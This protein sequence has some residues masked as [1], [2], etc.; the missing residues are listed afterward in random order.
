MKN[1]MFVLALVVLGALAIFPALA[2]GAANDPVDIV[3]A[4]IATVNTGDFD[5]ALAF[6]SDDA[7][8]KNPLGLF[9]GKEQIAGWLKND[10]QTTRATPKD[11]QATGNMV[12]V[13][14]MVSLA[15]FKQVGID[16][17]AFRSV[18][19]VA[20]G[21]LKFFAPTVQLTPE[22]Q[23]QAKA[24][25]PPA[26]APAIDPVGVVKQYIATANTGDF[27]KTLAFYADNAIVQNPLGLF[28]GKEQI[29][30]WLKNDVQTTRATPQQFIA[31]GNQVT[32]MGTV[33]LARFKQIG[34]DPV[35]YRSEYVVA[36]DKILYFSPTVLLTPEQQAKVQAAAKGQNPAPSTLPQTG[37][38][39]SSDNTLWIGG[40]LAGIIL[41]GLGFVV[42]RRTRRS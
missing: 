25:I 35:A 26:P 14:G 4:Y 17:V 13:T 10:V 32:N 7:I 12:V 33:S 34:I 39:V 37:A 36:G 9:V 2:H 23:A 28:V 24:K 40:L 16:P 31:N 15:R 30:G 19:V 22:Q 5:K 42:T 29:A 1:R 18:Y 21:K 6:Y 38:V 11:Y 8:V 41:L 27:D 20:D 3:K